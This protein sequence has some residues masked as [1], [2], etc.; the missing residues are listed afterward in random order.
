[1]NIPKNI[2]LMFSEKAKQFARKNFLFYKNIKLTFAEVE[3]KCN[4]M[5]RVLMDHGV[6]RGDRVAVM[7][8]NSPNFVYALFGAIKAGAAVVPINT[9][10]KEKEI[11]Y[12]INNCETNI[13][14]T[15]NNYTEALKGINE[16]C[17]LLKSVLSFS[18][19]PDMSGAVSVLPLMDEMSSKTY[20]SPA[21]HDDLALII[22]TSGTTGYPKGAMLS[23]FNLLS[24]VEMANIGYPITKKDRFLLFLPMF[25]IY[26]L[27]VAMMYPAY[28]GASVIILESVMDL[29]KK[30]FKNILLFQRPTVMTG[31]PSVYAALAKANMPQWFIKFLYPI[32]IH[33]C[34]GSGLPMEVFN[35]F[36]EKFKR[37]LIEGYGISEMSP[38]LAGNDADNPIA[39]TVGKAFYGVKTKIVNEDDIEVAPGEVGEIIA[40]GPNVMQGYWKM[41]KETAEVIKN[42]W[43]F[44]GD[45]GTMDAEGYIRIVDRKKDLILVKGMNVYPREI[46]EHIYK[47]EGVD[48]AAVLGIPNNEGDEII[49][50]YIKPADGYDISEKL[51]KKYLKDRIANFKIP[52]HVYFSDELPLTSIGKVLK[53]ELKVMVMN[54]KLKGI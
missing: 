14:I 49:I 40:T 8:E 33:M 3:K 52:K 47:I 22:Y 30:N 51:V 2:G 43:F 16:D 24:M 29:K 21:T 25:H 23:Q 50:A 54:G 18:D 34:S 15:S 36:K 13:L 11:S 38:V 35:T 17:Q 20:E 46:E 19:E 45:L 48:A 44:T 1:M 5:A 6:K 10:L 4:Q 26:S 41:P 32:K 39:G 31:V 12:I 9:F 27:M 42:G 28:I 53:R 7:V 37:P